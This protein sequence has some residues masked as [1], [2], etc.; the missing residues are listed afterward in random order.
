MAVALNDP[1]DQEVE[2]GGDDNVLTQTSSKN[3]KS[4]LISD[5]LVEINTDLW[6]T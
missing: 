5:D 3:M 6:D 4:D 1:N 2:T